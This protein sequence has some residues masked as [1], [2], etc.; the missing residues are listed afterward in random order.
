MPQRVRSTLPGTPNRPV[1]RRV[2]FVLD[3]MGDRRTNLEMVECGALQNPG[4]S[5]KDEYQAGPELHMFQR[6]MHF[7][8]ATLSAVACGKQHSAVSER[9][10]RPT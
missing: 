8:A 10:L 6:R 5:R 4:E 3:P 7:I 1:A 2:T 9:H